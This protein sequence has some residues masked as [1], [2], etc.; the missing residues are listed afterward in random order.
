MSPPTRIQQ[1]TAAIGS[2]KE[3]AP[4]HSQESGGSR[5]WGGLVEWGLS[6][7]GHPCREAGRRS[8]MWTSQRVDQ[9]VNKI[10]SIKK[11]D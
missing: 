2:V 7:G 3:D 6:G 11:N 8:E 9:E 4:N 1:M 5:K 10:W